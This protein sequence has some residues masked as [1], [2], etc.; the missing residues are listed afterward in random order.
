MREKLVDK[1]NLSGVLLC[2]FVF[3]FVSSIL[4][5]HWVQDVFPMGPIAKVL[6]IIMYSP[7]IIA[8]LCKTIL[9]VRNKS[10]L[11]GVNKFYYA[12]LLYYLFISVFRFVSHG[13]V[14]E[15]LYLFIV[16]SGS[17]AFLLFNLKCQFNKG[18]TLVFSLVAIALLLL[19]YRFSL[20]VL[21]PKVFRYPPINTNVLSCILLN[22]IIYFT[23]CLSVASAKRRWLVITIIVLSMV[24][25]LVSG[26]RA[27]FFLL[28]FVIGVSSV[29]L[30]VYKKRAAVLFGMCV[31]SAALIVSV[32]FAVGF[33]NVRSSVS[34]ELWI[35]NR[36]ILT[37]GNENDSFDSI[38]DQ[39]QIIE[40][41]N[42][43]IS[44][45][46]TGRQELVEN[47]LQEIGKDPLFGTG[48]VYYEQK[49]RETYIANQTSHCFLIES[50]VSFGSIGTILVFGLFLALVLDL[51]KK[52]G[53]R[54]KCFLVLTIVS[55]L[56]YC[57]VQPLF[58][59][60]IVSFVFVLIFCC[61]SLDD[62]V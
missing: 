24:L 55:H 53:R 4:I 14:K 51:F 2:S 8:I 11:S 18:Q 16:F 21:V 38:G 35:F 43:Q 59:E 13:E 7:Y 20:L 10:L 27:S 50:M 45:S 33:K 6:T 48:N 23:Y 54:E 52:I 25:V 3:I 42:E 44:R 15:S 37:E 30:F 12:L 61:Y 5:S 39:E 46:D 57:L 26:A 31:L 60:P 49:I 29:V 32:L 9:D 17:M 28:L 22:L 56:L 1:P 58:F 47:G 34:R 41:Q 19:L 62:K 36:L 40:E